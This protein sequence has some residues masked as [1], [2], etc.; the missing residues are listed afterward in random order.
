[1]A[2][3][4]GSSRNAPVVDL[5]V[6]VEALEK[7][8]LVQ[9]EGHQRLLQC[10]ERKRE[11]IRHADIN[12]IS[13]ICNQE[14]AILRRISDFEKHRLELIGRITQSLAPNA[15]APLTVSEIALQASEP[16]RSALQTAAAQLR[17]ALEA[18]RRESAVVRAAAESLSRHMSGILQTVHAALSRARVYGSRGRITLGAQVQSLVD[19]KS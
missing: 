13:E 19:V 9:L 11:A 6:M 15:S 2:E 10:I 8:L 5:A 3:K 16:Q 4:Q 7:I 18:V 12:A 1:M 17:D 14:H